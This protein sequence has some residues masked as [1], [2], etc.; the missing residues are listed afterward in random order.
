MKTMVTRSEMSR[1]LASINHINH[2]TA[3]NL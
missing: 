3:F 1:F 2:T